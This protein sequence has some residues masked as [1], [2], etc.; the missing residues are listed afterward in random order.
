VRL[1]AAA[2]SVA[3]LVLATGS[4]SLAQPL[5]HSARTFTPVP[6]PESKLETKTL[7]Q[8]L[9]SGNLQVAL[10]GR[11]CSC[12]FVL[13]GGIEIGKR[14]FLVAQGTQGLAYSHASAAIS[15]TKRGRTLLR[16]RSSGKIRILVWQK[17]DPT[18]LKPNRTRKL[19]V[20]LPGR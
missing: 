7:L 12:Q 14:W 5:S 18:R 15:L 9:T 11:P 8:A 3:G 2:A 13:Q 10:V 16:G 20:T 17:G 1:L 4:P 6:I 19:V